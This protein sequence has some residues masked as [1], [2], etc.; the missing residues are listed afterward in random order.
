MKKLLTY[1]LAPALVL[2]L[3]ATTP[4]FAQ[5]L[6]V[7]EPNG[8]NG[9]NGGNGRDYKDPVSAYVYAYKNRYVL[10]KVLKA[11][12]VLVLSYGIIP[13][14]GAA[15]SDVI[16]KQK[17]TNQTVDHDDLG[18]QGDPNPLNLDATASN[19]YN[20]NS[21]IIQANQDVGNMVNQGN[22]A[23]VALTGSNTALTDAN[24]AASQKNRGNISTT[25]VPFNLEV[26]NKEALIEDSLNTNSGVIHFNQNAGDMNNQ[27]NVTSVAVGDGSIVAMADSQLGQFNTGNQVF[28][29]NTQKRDRI[30]G[31]VNGN[32]GIVNVNQSS[33]KFNNQ[34][35]V[36]SFAGSAN[37]GP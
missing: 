30:L 28:D 17:N 34:A 26:W 4:A 8:D 14:D 23:S 20:T 37:I 35:T 25:R 36:V 6:L 18:P 16:V 19:S 32:S 13:T 31:S 5:E 10:E 11:K 24:A 33:G 29:T 7:E 15:E 12:L 1:A 2:A 3:G 22:V 9:D 21:G 27:L